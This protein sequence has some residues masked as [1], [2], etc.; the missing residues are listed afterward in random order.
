VNFLSG[1]GPTQSRSLPFSLPSF[2]APKIQT[3]TCQGRPTP[4]NRVFRGASAGRRR[5]RPPR[6]WR[7]EVLAQKRHLRQRPGNFLVPPGP[8]GHRRGAPLRAI[9][10]VA[11]TTPGNE[12][13]SH[14]CPLGPPIS[15]SARWPKLG[16]FG[17]TGHAT[18]LALFRAKTPGTQRNPNQ[19]RL[20]PLAIFA[21]LREIRSFLS[22]IRNVV[23]PG[24]DRGPQSAIEE[25]A[26]FCRS[27]L[28]VRCTITPFRQGT[29]P[30]RCSGQ[31]WLCLAPSCPGGVSRPPAPL[32][33]QPAQIG[34]VWRIGPSSQ[35]PAGLV[36]PGIGF[37]PHDRPQPGPRLPVRGSKL[38]L[39]CTS[40]FELHTSNLPQIGFVCATGPR[41]CEAA[42]AGWA[43]PLPSSPS[44]ERGHPRLRPVVAGS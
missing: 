31:N 20:F 15:G 10:F 27:L 29:C 9:G 42:D 23:T 44:P 11:G 40:H 26:L 35:C 18:E 30:S 7:S 12:A 3:T 32:A 1:T 21:S 43:V 28:R 41:R 2:F 4:K 38:G 19:M 8:A 16:L 17:A 5:I 13:L 39:F 25:L 14:N 24:C 37:V 34:F 33:G 6:G 36:P 22:S